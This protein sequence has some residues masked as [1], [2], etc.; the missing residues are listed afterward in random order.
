MATAA[1]MAS[2]INIGTLM[3]ASSVLARRGIAA[4]RAAAGVGA[5][6][7]RGIAAVGVGV[8]VGSAA[9]RGA[10]GAA[11]AAGVAGA[12]G[13]AARGAA[14]LSAGCAGV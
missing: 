2:M 3:V 14:S 9:G 1:A 4:D 5:A 12:A 7:G 6:V 13:V 8:G 10:V 11:V